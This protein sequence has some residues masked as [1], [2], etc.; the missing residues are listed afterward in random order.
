MQALSGN[1]GRRVETV[2]PG[3]RLGSGRLCWFACAGCA[4]FR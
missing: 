3:G 1:P 4:P 2:A